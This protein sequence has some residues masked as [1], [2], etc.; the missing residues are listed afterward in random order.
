M[1]LLREELLEYEKLGEKSI[2]S[3]M[4]HYDIS[5]QSQS[6]IST[7]TIKKQK[8]QVMQT[9]TTPYES[10]SGFSVLQSIQSLPTF[11][12]SL[13]GIKSSHRHSHSDYSYDYIPVDS[14]NDMDEEITFSS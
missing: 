6:P 1:S 12:T 11:W 14:F 3:F 7:S 13:L 10:S 4:Q 2:D 8:M 9:S 5:Y